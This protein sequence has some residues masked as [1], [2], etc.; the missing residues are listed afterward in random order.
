MLYLT[1]FSSLTTI[2]EIK[3]SSLLDARQ[4]L[5]HYL[6]FQF[7]RFTFFVDNPKNHDLVLGTGTLGIGQDDRTT[8]IVSQ[9]NLMTSLFLPLYT[10]EM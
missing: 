7:I 8:F 9:L 6:S 3:L 1:T 2:L 4:T 5:S 10:D